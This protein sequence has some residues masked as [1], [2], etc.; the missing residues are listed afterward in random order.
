MNINRGALL[1]MYKLLA[2]DMD[3]TL[4]NSK[5]QISTENLEAIKKAVDMGTKVVLASGRMFNGIYNYLEQ[6]NLLNDKN[7]SVA[8]AGAL[9]L[10]NTMSEVVESNNLGI[11]D[12]KYVY[13]IAKEHNL[14][15]N[16]YTK[17]SILA[18]QDDIYSRL[19][20]ITN[21]ANFKLVDLDSLN[22]VEIYK[23]TLINDSVNGVR[24]IKG[25]FKDLDIEDAKI[26]DMYPKE[27]KILEDDILDKISPY[28]SDRYTVVKPFQFSLEVIRKNCNKWTAIEKIA[29]KLGIKDE[30]IICIGDSENDEHMIKNAGLG[31]AMENGFSKIKEIA[32]Y[33]TYTNDQHGVAHAINKFIL[34]KELAYA[35]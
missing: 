7:Y 18:L 15:L 11:D 22:N 10:N 3:G 30:E 13:E 29:K 1:H 8:C 23:I 5:H 21:N 4:L 32:D 28:L 14:S 6:L 25:F 34:K 2:V 19:E 27:V 9:A 20:A 31:V 16:I 26:I 33:V 24:R 12:L 17:D 35:E